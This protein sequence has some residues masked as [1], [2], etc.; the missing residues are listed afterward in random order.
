MVAC[1]PVSMAI[2]SLVPTPSLAAT[3][4]GSLKPARFRSNKRAEAAEVDIGSRTA[5]GAGQRL[6]G[7]D[8]GVAGIDVDAGLAVGYG[9]AVV[10]ALWH[11]KLWRRSQFLPYLL[12][13]FG[14][15]ADHHG[16]R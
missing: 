11:G 15:I 2:L 3:R 1:C 14:G 4:I 7:L 5:R 13:G 6:D 16:I 10:A 12:T 9:R 8:Q